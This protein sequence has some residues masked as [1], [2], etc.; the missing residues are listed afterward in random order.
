MDRNEDAIAGGH[1]VST[2]PIE[3]VMLSAPGCAG[4]R[5]GIFKIPRTFNLT[6]GNSCFRRP[7][8]KTGNT[9]SISP[10]QNLSSP[11]GGLPG[12]PIT[13]K[14]P[15]HMPENSCRGPVCQPKGQGILKET[16]GV[17]YF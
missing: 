8:L 7:G 15:Y 13:A 11:S 3:T 5:T 14:A 6:A 10:P 17:N 4:D 12:S 1:F 16:R 2:L 9:T